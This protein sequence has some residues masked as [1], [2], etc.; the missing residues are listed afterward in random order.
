MKGAPQT[1]RQKI[2][3]KKINV[4]EREENGSRTRSQQAPEASTG[5]LKSAIPK[6][7]QAT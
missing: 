7:K 6:D 1:L 3:L 5:N 4:Q 2:L